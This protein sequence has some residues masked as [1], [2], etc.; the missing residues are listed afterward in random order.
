LPQVLPARASARVLL[1]AIVAG[2][3]AGV[4]VGFAG[5]AYVAGGM[6]QDAQ[7]SA[8]VAR[9]AIETAQTQ[10]L[11]A[12]PANGGAQAAPAPALGPARGDRLQ[13]QRASLGPAAKPYVLDSKRELDCLTEAVYYEARGETSDG[14]AAVAQVVLNRVRHPSFPKTVCAVVYQGCQ[15]SFACNGATRARQEVRAWNRARQVAEEA[16]SGGVFAAVGEATHFHVTSVRP[17]WG[18]LMRVAQIGTHVFYRFNGRAAT[19]RMAKAAAVDAP[20]VEL[21]ATDAV[22]VEAAVPQIVSAVLETTDPVAKVEITAPGTTAAPAV[23]A[24]PA[25]TATPA[26]PTPA[27]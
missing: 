6:A 7:R 16:L 23:T 2:A 8:Q 17:A 10:P 18:N 1:Y 25:K 14:Q 9:V 3:S 20:P 4:I 13:A 21:A 26:K 5:G 12:L 22:P 24:E 19:A 11:T 27:T 15:F